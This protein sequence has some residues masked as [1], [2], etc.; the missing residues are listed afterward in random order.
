VLPD[1]TT[2]KCTAP[3]TVLVV[4]DG[5]PYCRGHGLAEASRRPRCEVRTIPEE[6]TGTPAARIG[7]CPE[8]RSV[9]LVAI[10]AG[11]RETIA[12][13]YWKLTRDPMAGDVVVNPQ[14]G[15]ARLVDAA[16]LPA[17]V[18]WI[19]KGAT[20]H[21]NHGPLCVGSPGPHAG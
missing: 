8:C 18:G 7:S 12:V 17:V 20:L 10:L 14:T 16:S 6:L 1:C 13:G 4:K 19:E 9:V 5:K 2:P 21:A 3:A 15:Q 11:T